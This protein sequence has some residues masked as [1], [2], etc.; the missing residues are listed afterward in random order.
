[1]SELGADCIEKPMRD[2]HKRELAELLSGAGISDT[3]PADFRRFGSA[4][5]LYHWQPSRGTI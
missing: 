3:P 2:E 4:R 5:T 1:V